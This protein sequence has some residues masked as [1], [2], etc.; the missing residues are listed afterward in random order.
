MPGSCSQNSGQ[1]PSICFPRG[2]EGS[3]VGA[4]GT[5][6]RR[7]VVLATVPM[8]RPVAGA[9]LVTL[10]GPSG[11]SPFYNKDMEA[12][13]IKA[14]ARDHT[15]GIRGSPESVPCAGPRSVQVAWGGGEPE[16]FL[17]GRRASTPLG[18][19]QPFL[20]GPAGHR[21]DTE[22]LRTRGLGLRRRCCPQPWGPGGASTPRV[23][24]RP[25][26]PCMRWVGCSVR[27][28]P[29]GDCSQS[30]CCREGLPV[31]VGSQAG[32]G[33]THGCLAL[34]RDVTCVGLR[35][36]EPRREEASTASPP[37]AARGL[38]AR[39]HHPLRATQ[40]T[41]QLLRA[42]AQEGPGRRTRAAGVTCPWG[43]SRV[44]FLLILLPGNPGCSQA[45][46]PTH[47]L[48]LAHTRAHAQ[49]H[50]IH[51][52]PPTH[53][54]T[55]ARTLIHGHIPRSAAP[56]LPLTVHTHSQM[57][58]LSHTYRHSLTHTRIHSHTVH[59]HHTCA[60]SHTCA[61]ARAFTV[62]HPHSHHFPINQDAQRIWCLG[63][64][65]RAV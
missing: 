2:W 1:T 25:R 30:R 62:T 50:S 19:R 56:M 24:P 32:W 11:W 8:M 31:L 59:T 27:H 29:S 53:T 14:F 23:P 52:L 3:A 38:P 12:C 60:H 65:C 13:A 63:H 37:R 5:P 10:E 16:L 33:L 58:A 4:E 46:A 35:A 42:H 64:A 54:H 51:T 28:D 57:C 49:A 15:L 9:G 47:V 18:G 44:S 43:R 36:R 7:L 39:R 17:T 21:E 45:R 55:R 61:Y 34:R 22:G 40:E 26:P 20:R 48:T 6:P 41:Q